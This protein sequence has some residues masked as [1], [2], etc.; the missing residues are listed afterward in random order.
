MEFGY[1]FRD[2]S[3]SD[4]GTSGESWISDF[5]ISDIVYYCNII[6]DEIEIWENLELDQQEEIEKIL[7]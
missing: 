6:D 1:N 2:T 3:D 5:Q 7:N 4:T